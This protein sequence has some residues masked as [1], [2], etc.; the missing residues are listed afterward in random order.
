MNYRI[1][2]SKIKGNYKGFE[3][4]AVQYVQCCYDSRFERTK[5]TRDGN[6][7]ASLVRENY[8]IVMGYQMSECA[9]EEWWMEAKF[10]TET[11]HLTR[12]RL[13][14]TLVSAILK[15]TVG[16]V[17]FVT[18]IDVNAQTVND[19]R[20]ALTRATNCKEVDFC[21]KDCL[22]YWLY[23]NPDILK[24]FFVDYRGEP[25]E[26]PDLML[27]RQ[28]TF[29]AADRSNLVF[30]ESLSVLDRG[31]IYIARFSVYSNTQQNVRIQSAN[32][33]KGISIQSS[34]KLRLSVGINQ[35]EISFS[36]SEDYG[37]KSEKAKQEHIQLPSPAF[38]I[39]PLSIVP[40]RSIT[41]SSVLKKIYNLPSQEALMKK[42]KRCFESSMK[43]N[44]I[45]L[46]CISGQS[47]VGKSYVIDN[48]IDSVSYTNSLYFVCE[49]SDNQKNNLEN[50]IRCIDFIHFPFLPVDSINKDYL[51]CMR[52]D[53]FF[54]P[55]YYDI[56]CCER[57]TESIGKLLARYISEDICLF[58]RKLYVDPRIIIIDDI[59]KANGLI[60]NAIYKMA[61]ELSTINAPYMLV[62][63]GQKVQSTK[64]YNEL[65]KANYILEEE[66]CITDT[67]CLA[68]L[69]AN[70]VGLDMRHFF[71][72]TTLFPNVM[73][74]LFF[75]EYILDHGEQVNDFESFAT[76]Y[77]LFSQEKIMDA[78]IGRLFMTATKGDDAADTLCN[79][80]YWTTGGIE[81]S[82][83]SLEQKLLSFHVAKLD[84]F[85]NRIIPYHDI[86][87]AFYRK[88]YSCRSLGKLSLLELL[89]GDD[90]HA[91]KT[92]F[93][94]LH[95]AF[96]EEKYI[97][98]YYS[99]EVIFRDSVSKYK[100]LIN[101]TEYYTLFFEYALSC[102]HCSLDHSGQP[103]FARIYKETVNLL[104]P[105]PQLR[106]ICN[107][108]LWELTNSTFESLDYPRASFYSSQLKKNTADL[109]ERNIINGPL[110]RCIRYHNANVICSMI[111]SELQEDDFTLFF[112][113]SEKDMLKNGFEDRCWSFRVRYS[114]TLMQRAPE[115]A[116]KILSDCCNHYDQ[117]ADISPEK[118]SL[119]AHFYLSYMKIIVS[120][121]RS[122]EDVALLYFEQLRESFFNDYRKALFGMATYFY[123]QGE[124]QK[125]DQLL[126]SDC[127]V[128]RQ[129][130]PR[131]QG[132]FL[133]T[134]AARCVVSGDEKRALENLE[135][136]STFFR[137][138]PS[139]ERL[140]QHNISFLK[141]R[142]HSFKATTNHANRLLKYYLGGSLDDDW[143]YLD[144]RSCW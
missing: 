9:A 70:V 98:V 21:T 136:A 97:F 62:L 49:M 23:Q 53:Q 16:R 84:P 112:E 94:Q 77:K 73:E 22:E 34:T 71:S 66:L 121:D 137:A 63:S 3:K 141:T 106:K 38:K 59:H 127:R 122:Q 140:I 114:L 89:D 13:D 93:D 64:Y 39:G 110:S 82:D 10:S 119:W 40:E 128:V 2:W 24:K 116:M 130:R 129:R 20:Q 61:L 131:L 46:F 107:A 30:R 41:V 42:M 4:L 138:I 68:L 134:N 17:I 139:Y 8:T 60:T 105:S 50:Y 79:E 56:V 43:G 67:D 19:I 120:N 32:N 92:A 96:K 6:K 31:R 33:L 126:L 143:Y 45:G 7:D 78:Y 12:Y 74:I 1:N 18:N 57:D 36:L 55:L 72:S 75:A 28:M 48:F 124:I 26:L 58:P 144:I 85:T 81:S 25:I 100:N 108:A 11:R 80:I 86:Y 118:Y 109:I 95:D 99:L 37:Y 83:W 29:F 117:K 123:F 103:L 88:H 142:K 35:V 54:S 44:Q 111:K 102:A 101:E 69:P 14:A 91:R 133:L 47:G 15:G 90:A 5:D 132:F 65:F 87:T 51:D 76:L 52:T 27:V 104:H 125:G 113:Q 135:K 115:D